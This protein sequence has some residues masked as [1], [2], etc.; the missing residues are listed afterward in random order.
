ML[1][2]N[3]CDVLKQLGYPASPEVFF[4]KGELHIIAPGEPWEQGWALSAPRA[5]VPQALALLSTRA[6]EFLAAEP[7]RA[8]LNKRLHGYVGLQLGPLQL[9]GLGLI[10]LFPSPPPDSSVLSFLGQKKLSYQ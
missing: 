10:L 5:T 3:A 1:L 9:W 8:A 6:E 7:I 2:F 4:Y